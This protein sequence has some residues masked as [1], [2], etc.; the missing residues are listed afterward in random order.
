[1]PV[2][3]ARRSGMFYIDAIRSASNEY[4]PCVHLI[5]RGSPFR[6]IEKN[7]FH[8][9]S[10]RRNAVLYRL[11]RFGSIPRRPYLISLVEFEGFR[12]VFSSNV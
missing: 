2:G 8:N 11:Q 5:N 3:R 6:H 1:M 4:S 7:V 10:N 9:F 12:E